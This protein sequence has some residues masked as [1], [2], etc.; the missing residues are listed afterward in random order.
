MNRFEVF[1][2]AEGCTD[3]SIGIA[4]DRAD[5]VPLIEQHSGLGASFVG[6]SDKYDEVWNVGE[7]GDV[8]KDGARADR[9]CYAVKPVKP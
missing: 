4:R 1:Y 6:D 2:C 3:R 7:A 8:L 5:V 9:V